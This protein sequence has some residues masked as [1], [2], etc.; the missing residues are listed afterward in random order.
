MRAVGDIE[1]PRALDPAAAFVFDVIRPHDAADDVGEILGMLQVDFLVDRRHVAGGQF[2][3]GE[4]VAVL[5]R[6]GP[7]ENE[8]E[9]RIA[10]GLVQCR[11]LGLEPGERI[12]RQLH[13]ERGVTCRRCPR[14]RF[15]PRR[16]T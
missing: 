13:G 12:K 1:F 14:I 10:R 16:A 5:V 6:A 3:G 11:R 7:A 2:V 15:G 8:G 9:L 4:V